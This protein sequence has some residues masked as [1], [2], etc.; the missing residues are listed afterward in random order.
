MHI[1]PHAMIHI[2]R[3]EGNLLESAVSFLGIESRL[4]DLVEAVLS[5][6]PSCYPLNEIFCHKHLP[7]KEGWFLGAGHGSVHPTPFPELGTFF[8]CWA[9]V[10]TFSD[11]G[12]KW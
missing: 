5:A 10:P 4:L 1:P 2:R 11:L 6:K 3:S 8:F 9:L 12:V 7:P